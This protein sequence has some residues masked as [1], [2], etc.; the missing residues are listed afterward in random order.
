MVG[1]CFSPLV[2]VDT[3]ISGVTNASSC[4]VIQ[5]SIVYRNFPGTTK[6]VA[7]VDHLRLQFCRE[8]RPGMKQCHVISSRSYAALTSDG[9]SSASAYSR[10]L[11]RMFVLG[12]AL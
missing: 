8:P 1:E 3:A 7:V 5:M 9:I 4:Y 6:F 2:W 12:L 11:N 10:P